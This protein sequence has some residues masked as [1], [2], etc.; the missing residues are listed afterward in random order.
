MYYIE[1]DEKQLYPDTTVKS[2][3]RMEKG[4]EIMKKQWF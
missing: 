1:K 2:R 3:E 4:G